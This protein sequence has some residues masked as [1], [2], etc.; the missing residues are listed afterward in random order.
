MFCVPKFDWISVSGFA[1]QDR[2]IGH[3]KNKLYQNCYPQKISEKSSDPKKQEPRGHPTW[4][5]NVAWIIV[6]YSS[7]R[8]SWPLLALYDWEEWILVLR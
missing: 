2:L 8:V 4:A 6:N 1:N 7:T 3:P 5:S